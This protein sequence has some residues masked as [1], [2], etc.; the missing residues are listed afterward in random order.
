MMWVKE[1]PGQPMKT[2]F[3]FMNTFIKEK[4]EAETPEMKARVEE[5]RQQILTS[6]PADRNL[7]FQ[8]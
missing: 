7:A 1:N 8:K 2:R 5:Y 6:S 4:F 3:E